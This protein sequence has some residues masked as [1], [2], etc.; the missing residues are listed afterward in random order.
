MP[1]QPM[2]FCEVFDVWGIDFMGPIPIFFGFTYTLLAVDYVSKWVEAKATRTNDAR[3]VVDF[4]RSH[5][6]CRFG[7]SRAI[8][9][10]QG[11]HF[12]N[13]SM[14]FCF[15]STGLCT[16]FLPHITPK[17]MGKPR[18]EIEKSRGSWR[19]LCNPTERIGVIDLKMLY[20]L[21]GLR[22]RHL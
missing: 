19:R 17:L 11:T 18:S 3:V 12:C 8:V 1:Q 2:L 16:N 14:G 13:R 21:T 15:Q 10:D 20:G 6:F 7:V 5:I 22:T 9:S 4:V